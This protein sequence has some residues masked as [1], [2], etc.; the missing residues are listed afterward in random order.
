LADRLTEQQEWPLSQCGV[1]SSSIRSPD[2]VF[3]GAQPATGWLAGQFAEDA[4]GF[5]ITGAGIP[6]DKLDDVGRMP[7]F[8]ETGRP[9]IFAV[10][11]VR[12]G[13]VKRAAT[14]IGEGSMAVRLVYERLQATGTA[15]VDPPRAGG[16]G[17]GPGRHQVDVPR[18]SDQVRDKLD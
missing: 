16:D 8:L 12:S 10:G 14:A 11:D 13:S 9:G 2:F 3:I 5:L 1:V 15:V 17:R 7:L 18:P 6:D 4:R